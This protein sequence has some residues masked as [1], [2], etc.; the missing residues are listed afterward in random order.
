MPRGPRQGPR[1]FPVVAQAL[2]DPRLQP[3]GRFSKLGLDLELDDDFHS[4]NLDV[5]DEVGA[6]CRFGAIFY[7]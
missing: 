7:V 5:L 1:R 6:R 3:E 4:A 2:H